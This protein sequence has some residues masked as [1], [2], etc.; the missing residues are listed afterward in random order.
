MAD[1]ILVFDYNNYLI[2]HKHNRLFLNEIA[3]IARANKLVN[4][5]HCKATVIGTLQH[6]AEEFKNLITLIFGPY[7]ASV[8]ILREDCPR[9][10]LFEDKQIQ[11]ISSNVCLSV[12]IKITIFKTSL[13]NCLQ[14]YSNH[15]E[16]NRPTS[17]STLTTCSFPCSKATRRPPTKPVAS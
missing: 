10:D 4:P 6:N 3:D 16:T 14:A 7:V 15:F 17:P 13:D 5:E 9:V 1:A 11:I 2:Y 12:F 8:R